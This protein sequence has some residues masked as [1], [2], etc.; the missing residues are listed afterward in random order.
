MK[1]STAVIIV[2]VIA[3]VGF[4]I[5]KQAN[6]FPLPKGE[7][8]PLDD[9]ISTISS[10]DGE[11]QDKSQDKPMDDTKDI[12]ETKSN[13]REIFVTGGTKHSIPLDEILSG[14]PPKDGIP[15]INDPKFITTEEAD[16][17]LDDSSVG[18][19]LTLNGINR[20][21]PYLVLV[22]HELA[23]DN[24]GG[25]AVLVSYCPLCATGV[26]FDSKVG[27]ED[28][29]FGVSGKLWQSN[30]LMYNRTGNEDTESLWSQ[31]LGEA[32]VGPCGVK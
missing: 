9:T 21:Y 32:V 29:E 12:S 4:F 23:N 6:Q 10:D 7:T 1:V 5:F 16:K 20:F 28:Q 19:G 22:W 8:V 2:V 30:L 3:L 31:V 18:L 25:Q 15:A 11:E 14:G 24:I 26:V 13:T 27:G 17:F